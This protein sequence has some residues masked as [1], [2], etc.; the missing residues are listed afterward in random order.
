MKNIKFKNLF[1]L[2]MLIISLLILSFQTVTTTFLFNAQQT[3][4]YVKELA[5]PVYQ[6]RKPSTEG[7]LKALDFAENELLKSGY[8][9]IRQPFTALIPI[10]AQTPKLELI[11]E[12][13]QIINSFVHRKDFRESLSGY[14]GD[15]EAETKFI[16]D[17]LSSNDIKGKIFENS[18][19]IVN[20]DYNYRE[21]QDYNY[22]KAKVKAILVP[23]SDY[24]VSKASGFPGYNK[25]SFLN[26]SNKIVK[27]AITYETFNLLK[28]KCEIL[29]ENILVSKSVKLRASSKLFFK[30]VQTENIIALF[31]D[32]SDK[33]YLGF[34]A[35][36]DHLGADPDGSY[37]P[38]A[39]DNASGTAFTMEIARVLAAYKDRLTVKPIAIL[40]NAEENGLVGSHYFVRSGFINLSKLQLINSD[41]VGSVEPVAYNLLYYQGNKL[42]HPAKN[43]AILLKNF[44]ERNNFYISINNIS[45]D[46]DHYFFNEAGYTAVSFNQFPP[47]FYHTYNDTA[48]QVSEEELG[49]FGRFIEQFILENY[50]VKTQ[51]LSS[52]LMVI[53]SLALILSLKGKNYR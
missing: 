21:D 1:Y 22:I 26:K 47:E 33:N 16:V 27:F 31:D 23:T 50:T 13:N 34:S 39:L 9:V 45:G 44:G 5:S 11:D 18:I 48:N 52:F 4:S 30:K 12:N 15:G 51:S 7:N 6:G 43:F 20:N 42:N 8:K 53:F 24:A 41:M 3:Y 32:S 25:E 35:H 19:V 28:S 17:G 14:S 36:I 29:Q 37:F 10:L 46:T 40:F 2:I 49:N 38:G